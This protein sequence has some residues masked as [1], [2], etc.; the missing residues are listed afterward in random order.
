MICL[1]KPRTRQVSPRQLLIKI[2]LTED[3]CGDTGIVQTCQDAA[4]DLYRAERK[5]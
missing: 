2:V 1:W 3:V 5:E 4:D